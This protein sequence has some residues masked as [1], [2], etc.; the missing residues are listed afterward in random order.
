MRWAQAQLEKEERVRKHLEELASQYQKSTVELKQNAQK[1][2]EAAAQKQ[3]G[4]RK[5]KK[6]PKKRV[7]VESPEQADVCLALP[8]RRRY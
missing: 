6:G 1:A 2:S 4:G 3:G 7:T 5:K 8:N